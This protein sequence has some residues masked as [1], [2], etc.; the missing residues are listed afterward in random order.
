MK[1]INDYELTE[2][3]DEFLDEYDSIKILGMSYPVSDTLR[4][5][6]IVAYNTAFSDW[7]DGKTGDACV[8]EID[9]NY[10]VKD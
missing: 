3:F 4:L 2:M 1:Q 6:D 5:V 8:F 9:G 10:F 7:L